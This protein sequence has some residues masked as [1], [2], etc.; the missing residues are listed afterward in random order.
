M[1]YVNPS[2]KDVEAAMKDLKCIRNVCIL[3]HVDHGKTTLA[4]Q[5]LTSNRIVNARMAGSVRYLDDRHDEQ[6]RQI[7]MKSSGVALLNMVQDGKNTFKL[8]LNLIDTPGHIDF[9]SEAA[10]AVRVSSC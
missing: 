9:S 8:L 3:A 4:D 10:A 7:T 5:L 1:E 6:Q 2:L